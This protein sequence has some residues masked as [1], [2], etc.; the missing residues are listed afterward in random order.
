[1]LTIISQRVIKSPLLGALESIEKSYIKYF[2]QNSFL[3]ITMPNYACNF[4]SYL[5][6]LN[7]RRVILTGGGDIH[8]GSKNFSMSRYKTEIKL[9]EYCIDNRIPLLGICRGS[10]IIN[11]Y[12][13]G[14]LNQPYV[15]TSHV[16][17]IHPIKIID[18][19]IVNG[20][21]GKYTYD[22]NSY[23]NY[24]IC[25]EGLSTQ[26]QPFAVSEDS[27]IEAFTHKSFP[28]VG[29]MWHPEREGSCNTI[30]DFLIKDFYDPF[31][32]FN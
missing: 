29:V 25:H 24:V 13:G 19:K 11:E 26:L 23:H 5:A 3:L 7:I 15:S 1:M 9:I 32:L 12:F 17:T 28:I 4:D 6:E 16:N 14:Y 31:Y 21:H 27:T 30:N 8:Y 10:Q 22:V 20:L 18:S 2:S